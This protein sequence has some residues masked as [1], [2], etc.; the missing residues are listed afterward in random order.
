MAE[1]AVGR[2]YITRARVVLQGS[3]P[4]EMLAGYRR[5]RHAF[6]A[7]GADGLRQELER[8][9]C[10]LPMVMVPLAKWTT[11][12]LLLLPPPPPSSPPPPPL[13][14]PL[15]LLLLLLPPPPLPQL[16]PPLPP[17]LLQLQLQWQFL[18]VCSSL[19]RRGPQIGCT[20][21]PGTS[22]ATTA[23]SARTAG[24]RGFRT[25]MRTWW[26]SSERCRITALQTL[27]NI[28]RNPLS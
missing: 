15:P 14:P 1:A 27:G 4:D 11:P 12:R 23:A 8:G 5:H 18:C 3:G 21:G 26:P 17:L 16:P 9:A 19:D 24:S 2:V 28:E 20:T 13:S 25:L 10:L 22:A 6:A 7:G